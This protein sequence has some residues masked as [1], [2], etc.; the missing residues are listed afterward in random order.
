MGANS[1]GGS[2]S[3]PSTYKFPQ[4]GGEITCRQGAVAIDGI[5]IG[6]RLYRWYDVIKIEDKKNG[7]YAYVAIAPEKPKKSGWF[8][9]GPDPD[10]NV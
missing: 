4:D 9:G 2:S 5:M 1:G 3:G 10:E 7:I 6:D 8:S